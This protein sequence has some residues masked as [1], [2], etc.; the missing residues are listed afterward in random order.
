MIVTRNHSRPRLSRLLLGSTAEGAVPIATCPVL[1][2]HYGKARTQRPRASANARFPTKERSDLFGF[3]A[4]PL[5]FT[6]LRAVE[7]TPTELSGR[8]EPSVTLF[9]FVAWQPCRD[10]RRAVGGR[11]TGPAVTPP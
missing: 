2:V 7:S 1:A 6:A 10:A 8:I 9:Q 4:A 3:S 11:R 5:H